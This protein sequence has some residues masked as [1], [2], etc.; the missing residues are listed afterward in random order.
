MKKFLSV[1]L[2][3]IMSVAAFAS[4][5]KVTGGK[6]GIGYTIEQDKYLF[7][8]GE[9]PNLGSGGAVD[10]KATGEMTADLTG[11]LGA[12]SYRIWM[13]LTSILQREPGTDNIS[14]RAD[15]LQIYHDYIDKLKAT[16]IEH[17][18]AMS[19]YYLYPDGFAGGNYGNVIPEP[20]TEDYARFLD[21]ITECYKLLSAEF[22]EIIYWE[23]GNETNSE[24]FIA[25]QGYMAGG[26]KVANADYLYTLTEQAQITTDI[27]YYCEL[28][29][30]ATDKGQATVLPGL[31][32]SGLEAE[33]FLDDIYTS[34]ESG[35]FPR[36]NAKKD[37]EADNYFQVL[38]WHPYQFGNSSAD[39]ID[40]NKSLYKVAQKHGDD[41][42]KVFLTELGVPDRIAA[43]VPVDGEGNILWDEKQDDI[44]L[45]M[46]NQFE[47]IK[48]H[49][50]WIETVHMFRLF[51][52]KVN[53]DPALPGD[54]I[55][56]TF[57]LYTTPNNTTF[58]PQPKPVALAL[59]K[60]FNGENADTAPL[61]KYSLK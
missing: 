53:V 23:P 17:F 9:M 51:D 35:K 24:R 49:L 61:Y 36:G 18:T 45:W 56:K 5:D 22:P 12:Q 29:L 42:K 7:G 19:H 28:G 4:C 8:M 54:S 39:W 6:K 48:K 52:W 60:H 58:G 14:F 13:H 34:I 3:C 26:S 47:D 57:G 41:G 31:V 11:A 20:G 44:A 55:E 40:K 37:T 59:F 25:K 2:I 43:Q 46:V 27:S 10:S 32:F 21:M 15:R 30:K 50:P 1:L 33:F 38:N 16:G